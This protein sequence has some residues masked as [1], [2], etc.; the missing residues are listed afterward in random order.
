[1]NSSLPKLLVSLRL[2]VTFTTALFISNLFSIAFAD[3][4]SPRL[5]TS[6]GAELQQ[7]I[8][9]IQQNLPHVQQQ[10]FASALTT[11]YTAVATRSMMDDVDIYTLKAELD[12][13]L[14]GMSA[15]EVIAY[16]RELVEEGEY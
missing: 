4:Q 7:S 9:L 6:S 10:N 8:S 16:A 14:H 3:A 15:E 11:I 12:A 5:N 13:K 1:M 2:A